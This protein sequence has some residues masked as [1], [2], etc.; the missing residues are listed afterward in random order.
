MWL[1][2]V[3]SDKTVRSANPT[4]FMAQ[5]REIVDEALPGDIIGLHDTGNL[6]IGDTLTEGEK[7]IFKGVP[8]FFSG[9]FQDCG[10]FGS[11]ED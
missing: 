11:F 3:R 5:E 10:E 9:D 6:K 7:F 8:S 2:N 4:G 1:F